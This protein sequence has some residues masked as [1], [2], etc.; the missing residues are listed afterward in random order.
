MDPVAALGLALDPLGL[1]LRGGFHP[2]SE[3]GVPD[4]RDGRGAGTL[5]LVG[6][7]GRDM[8]PVFSRS[9]ELQDG[10]PNALDRWTRRILGQVAQELDA[11]ALF[12]FGGPPWLPFQRWA[13]R[14]GSVAASPLRI[15]IHPGYGL[16]HAYRGALAFA[17]RLALPEPDRRPRP[18][19]SCA[20]KPCLSACPV[21][22]FTLEGY[23]AARCRRHVASA[24]G[25]ACREGGCLARRACPV[26]REHAYPDAQMA[27]HMRAFLAGPPGT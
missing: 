6:N 9:A 14:A 5:Y 16:W 3:D 20:A 12:P 18:C 13:L 8:W 22:A 25:A 15:L 19:D 21:G 11:V 24:A 2:T 26:G 27:F 17:G 4:L 10:A 23:D 1:S 7:L